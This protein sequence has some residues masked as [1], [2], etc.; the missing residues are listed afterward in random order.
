MSVSAVGPLENVKLFLDNITVLWTVGAEV[1]KRNRRLNAGD[2][3]IRCH[4]PPVQLDYCIQFAGWRLLRLYSWAWPV[5]NPYTIVAITAHVVEERLE[6][7][8]ISCNG[9]KTWLAGFV[10]RPRPFRQIGCVLLCHDHHAAAGAAG[11]GSLASYYM[12]TL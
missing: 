10:R 4:D 7:K 12:E 6:M 1:Y 3:V 5:H 9:Y 11:H 8:S 2:T